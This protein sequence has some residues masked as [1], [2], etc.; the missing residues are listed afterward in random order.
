MVGWRV[1]VPEIRPSGL[2]R[3]P[4]DVLSKVLVRGPLGRRPGTRFRLCS[5]CVALLEGVGDVLEEDEAEDDVFVL[6]GVHAA[7]ES[8]GHAPELGLVAGDGVAG[9]GCSAGGHCRFSEVGCG[10]PSVTHG[11]G[12]GQVVV[13]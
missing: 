13:G 12:S 1:V 9:F 11:V 4:E 6:G 8:V 7:P 5:S 10:V 3:H 2:G